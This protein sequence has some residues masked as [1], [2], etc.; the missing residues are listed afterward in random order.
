MIRLCLFVSLALASP[1]RA[2][3]SV[4]TLA[5]QALISGSTNGTGTN[6]LFSDPAAIVAD[7]SGNLFVADSQ[8]HAIRRISTIGLVTTLAG[9]LGVPGRGDDT[10]AQAQFDSPCGIALDKNGNLFVADTGNHTVRKITPAGVVTTMAGVAGQGGFANGPGASALFNSPLGIA[11]TTN[12][13]IYVADSG[14]HVLRA[15]SP[16][17]SVTTLAGNPE[18][19]GVENGSGTNARFN[20]P[21]GLALDGQEN[22]F[23]ADS[24]NHTI[25][26]ITP[27]GSVSTWAGIPGV[28]GCVGGDAQSA[29]FCKP[30]ELAF[31]RQNN[32]FVADS[33]NHVIRKIAPDGKVSTVTGAAR[34]PGAADG[35]NG[36]ARLFNPYGVAI[37]PAGSLF[38][39]DAYNQLIRIV[40]VPFDLGIRRNN[41]AV[42]ISWDG[43][44]GKKYQVQY[45]NALDAAAW[46]NLGD[47]IAAANPIVSRTDENLS[48]GTQ[49]IY[50][51][52]VVE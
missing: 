22:L 3:D 39:A 19:W 7:A 14:N 8:N 1:L 17:G 47:P 40:L 20:G 34:N 21:V 12:G 33:F 49:R 46:T 38:V 42:T 25:R 29:T 28:D 31:D 23:V 30:A 50:R 43:V 9:Q 4:V 24:N 44:V 16:N 26:K 13:T 45:K 15:I 37:S 41:D 32:L 10:G 48:P 35:I 5:G 18:N 2:Q 36:Q 6:A 51:V 52:M 27:D 11:V